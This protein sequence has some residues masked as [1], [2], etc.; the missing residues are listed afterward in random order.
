MLNQAGSCLIK[1]GRK[2]LKDPWLCIFTF[3]PCA[4]LMRLMPQSW[5][6]VLFY[7]PNPH[8]IYLSDP[9]PC[10]QHAAEVQPGGRGQRGGAAARGAGRGAGPPHRG[11]QRHTP[12]E[13][14]HPGDRQGLHSSSRRQTGPGGPHPGGEKHAGIM[15]AAETINHLPVFKVWRR[16]RL[17]P[18][19][20]D[21]DQHVFT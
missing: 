6:F 21:T 5:L 13:H 10:R 14:C 11:G 20:R 3:K 15:E 18:A 4:Y 7:K 8:L 17:L 2:D 16:R 19:R 9:R 12:G 1:R